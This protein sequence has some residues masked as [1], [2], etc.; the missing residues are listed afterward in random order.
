MKTETI[1][2]HDLTSDTPIDEQMLFDD[3]GRITVGCHVGCG[4][5][6]DETMDNQ[7][8]YPQRWALMPRGVREQH[9]E[10]NQNE[11]AKN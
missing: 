9:N 2:W 4:E 5:C 3:E 1:T 10:E 7:V 6:W 11:S 8:F